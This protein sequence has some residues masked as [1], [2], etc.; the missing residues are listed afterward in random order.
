MNGTWLIQGLGMQQP[1]QQAG[2]DA[3]DLWQLYLNKGGTIRELRQLEESQIELMY[4]LGYSQYGSGHYKEALNVFRYLALLDHHDPRFFLGIGLSLYQ[5]HQNAAAI[6]ALNYAQKLDVEDPRPEICMTECYI[7][8]KN[9]KM[10]TK[11]LAGAVKKI[12]QGKGWQKER[13][14]AKQLKHY[15]IQAS[16]GK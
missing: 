2:T 16:G 7:R 8:L 1:K 14:Q 4:Q 10:A 3:Q 15:L 5:L 6:P 11:A 12:K 13:K 9:R